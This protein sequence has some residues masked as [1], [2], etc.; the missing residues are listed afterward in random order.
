MIFLRVSCTEQPAS[1]VDLP[2]SQVLSL[3]IV[4]LGTPLSIVDPHKAAGP[5]NRTGWVLRGCP[6]QLSDM[7][8]DIFNIVGS[9]AVVLYYF[10]TVTINRFDQ[11]I[12][13]HI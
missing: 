2:S 13:K 11:L 6:D 5:D 10:K 12:M 7:T 9:Q 1:K 3:S 4:N 8:I